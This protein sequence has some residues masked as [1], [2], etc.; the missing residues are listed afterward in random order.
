MPNWCENSVTIKSNDQEKL[1]KLH[2]AMV[3]GN[4]LKSVIPIPEEL[5]SDKLSSFGQESILHQDSNQLAR[6]IY[7]DGKTE[8]LG[9]LVQ[10]SKELAKTLD[11]YTV[12]EGKFYTTTPI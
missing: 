9:K 10:V 2:D 11:N 7:A 4:F 6:L 8:V 3:A 5:K 1:V 12:M